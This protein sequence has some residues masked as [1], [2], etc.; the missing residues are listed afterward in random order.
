MRNPAFGICKKKGSDQLCGN[1]VADQCFCFC[2]I[3]EGC[4]KNTRT[5]AAI[6]SVFD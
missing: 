6:P 2:C 1:R 4:S 3:Y 5:D